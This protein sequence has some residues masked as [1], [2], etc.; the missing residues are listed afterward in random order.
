MTVILLFALFSG[1]VM[2]LRPQDAVARIKRRMSEG[3]DHFYEE[4]RSYAAYP[5]LRDVSATRRRGWLLI[6]A[7]LVGLISQLHR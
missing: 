4:Q 1:L 3:S 2:A 6:I 5:W 7:S